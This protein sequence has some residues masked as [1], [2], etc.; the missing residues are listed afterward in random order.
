MDDIIDKLKLLKYQRDFCPKH[1]FKPLS[2]A[3]FEIQSQNPNQQLHYFNSLFS[4]LMKLCN[5]N[6]EAPSEYDDPNVTSTNIVNQLKVLNIP[7]DHPPTKLRQGNGE[8]VI[9]VLNAV[10]NLALKRTGFV[11]KKPVHKQEEFV[12]EAEVDEKAEVT[13]EMIDDMIEAE[14]DD[15]DEMYINNVSSGKTEVNQEPKQSP[16]AS[17]SNI[18]PT[19]WKLE[20]ERVTPMLKVQI[21]NDNKDW[22]IHLQQMIQ[23]DTS[24]DTEISDTK[25]HLNRLRSEIE[26]TLE[27]L[28]SREKYINSQFDTLIEEYRSTQDTLSRYRHEYNAT[29]ETVSNLSKDLM[30]ISDDLDAV[31]VKLVYLYVVLNVLALDY[32]IDGSEMDDLGSGMTDSKPLINIKQ[33]LARLK[34]ENKD[35]D[36]KIGVLEHKILM[37]RLNSKRNS[38]IGTNESAVGGLAGLG[39]DVENERV[40]KSSRGRK[41]V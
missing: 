32:F 35:M 19:S 27:K 39:I 22:R 2:K 3:Y 8:A 9:Y 30:K 6:F 1:K 11:F 4:W 16:N 38:V 26:T 10:L 33:S 21:P 36:I 14:Q 23:H 28:Q 34:S 5:E 7:F 41:Q 15:G 31:K 18:D 20:V 13:T 37:W 12:E 24:I 17:I 25:T 29:N 40:E